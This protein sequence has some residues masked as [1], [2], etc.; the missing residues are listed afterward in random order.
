MEEDEVVPPLRGRAANEVG[1]IK[2]IP[3]SSSFCELWGRAKGP[4]LP[5][6]VLICTV[7]G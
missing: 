5:A 3:G 7:A 1:S 6:E 4:D 2:C